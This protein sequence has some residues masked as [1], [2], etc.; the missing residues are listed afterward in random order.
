MYKYAKVAVQSTNTEQAQQKQTN[1]G[2]TNFP[3]TSTALLLSPEKPSSTSSSSKSSKRH[4]L[5]RT[6]ADSERERAAQKT[7]REEGA[8]EEEESESYQTPGNGSLRFCNDR[9]DEDKNQK[10]G[11]FTPAEEKLLKIKFTSKGPALFGSVQNLKEESIISRSEVKSFLHKESAYTKYRT[12]RR[13]SPRLKVLVY[14]IDEKWSIDLAYVD[15]LA[16]YNKNIKY[17]MVAVD[18]MSLS[19]CTTI[20]IKVCHLNCGSIQINDENKTANK[21]LSR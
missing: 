3:S 11:K 8:A 9:E 13:K 21:S 2:S 12:V 15:K 7:K 18:C 10:N 17:L 19:T 16:D 1:R 6:V 20:E 5:R 14:D 4:K